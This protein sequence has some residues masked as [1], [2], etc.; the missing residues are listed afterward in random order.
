M[1]KSRYLNHFFLRFN[2]NK[3]KLIEQ[4]KLQIN[5]LLQEAE[6]AA[7]QAHLA[8]I[9]DQ[10]VA[11]TQYDTLAIEAAYLAEGQS[12]RIELYKHELQQL[13]ALPKLDIEYKQVSSGCIV[14]LE[15]DDGLKQ[16]FWLLPVAGGQVLD[17]EDKTITVITLEAPFAKAMIGLNLDDE[18]E[19]VIHRQ[20]HQFYIGAIF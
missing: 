6:F 12:K 18:F 15:R 5:Q 20:N 2:M 11:E 19:F 3:S 16:C 13:E 10:S 7:Q 8:A 1:I 14:M 17:F 4:L 9:D